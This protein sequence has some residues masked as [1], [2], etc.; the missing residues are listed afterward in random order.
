MNALLSFSDIS[1]KF[2]VAPRL[3]T[4]AFSRITVPH[5]QAAG[6]APKGVLT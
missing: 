6:L 4:G 2:S 3:C 1:A 5:R